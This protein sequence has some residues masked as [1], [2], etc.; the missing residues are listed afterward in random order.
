MIFEDR[1]LKS[2][3]KLE[4]KIEFPENMRVGRIKR[5]NTDN[6]TLKDFEEFQREIKEAFFNLPVGKYKFVTVGKRGYLKYPRSLNPI[7]EEFLRKMERYINREWNIRERKSYLLYKDEVDETVLHGELGEGLGILEKG[8]KKEFF[9][10]IGYFFNGSEEYPFGEPIQHWDYGFKVGDRYCLALI[11]YSISSDIVM[12]AND[13][14]NGIMSDFLHVLHVETLPQMKA[15]SVVASAIAITEKTMPDPEVLS[16][17]KH[18]QTKIQSKEASLSMFS[19]VLF[20]FGEDEK[21]LINEAYRIKS[22]AN[23]PLSFDDTIGFDMVFILTDFDFLKNKD[24]FGIVRKA[25]PDY[26][27]TLLPVT[28]RYNGKPEGT[29]I[30]MINSAGE[31]AYIHVDKSLFNAV[32]IGQ[33]GAG[34]SVKM[35]YESTM[36][37]MSIFV[38]KI[39]SDVGSYAVYCSYFD[40]DYIPISLNIPVSINPLGKAYEYFTVDIYR[41]LSDL[42]VKNPHKEFD[43]SE[44]NAFSVL[45]DSYVFKEKK[46]KLTKEELI[47]IAKEDEKC[48]RFLRLFEE[49][50]DFVVDVEFTVNS[51]RKTFINTILTMMYKGND[52]DIPELSEVQTV[53]ERITDRFYSEVFKENPDKE[54]LISDLYRYI[55][56]N[57]EEGKIKER[58][59]NRL[60]SFKEGGQYGHLFDAPTSIKE[61]ENVFFEIRFENEEI[62][63]IVILTIM[64]YVDRVYGSVKYKDKTKLLVLD[65]GWFILKQKIARQYVEEAFRT[66]RKRGIFIEFG[67][68]SPKDVEEFRNYLPY[69][70]ILY[71]EN[72]EEA[73][74]V[75]DLTDRDISLMKTIDKPKAYKYR[76]SKMFIKFK[77]EFGKTEKGLFILPSYPE[78]R[79]IAETDP[80]FKLQRE[81]AIRKTGNLR[82]AI[83]YLSFKKGA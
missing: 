9:K 20:L 28:G 13:F 60:Y 4:P 79:W 43:E 32:T 68:Q 36:F 45:I 11:Q 59:L 17:L 62:I 29:F 40:G 54:M 44:R 26:V 73:V 82:K 49:K 75:F 69:V 70:F 16:Q 67:T 15:E 38:E 78:F 58:L 56:E 53:I 46:K 72:P 10:D 31:P 76:Y 39:Q 66:F 48:I 18:L 63:P 7:K 22:Q 12:F 21:Q 47:K 2:L 27:S 23:Y 57:V 3:F 41:L 37:D 55:E 71:M 42:G 52:E 34:K 14:L 51:A 30:P 65:E 5:V 1:Y 8:D 81:E 83:E 25:L 19:Q 61:S 50:E 33:M 74:A 77:N 64:D 80:V 6:F 35:Q 24:V